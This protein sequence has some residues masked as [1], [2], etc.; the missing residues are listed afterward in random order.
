MLAKIT[1]TWRQALLIVQPATLL[2]WHRQRCRLFWKWK[3]RTCQPQPRSAAETS[4]LIRRM[5]TEN[6][7]WGAEH[8]RGELLKLGIEVAKRTIQQYTDRSDVSAAVRL[9][10]RRTE[11]T[12]CRSLWGDGVP[13]L[14]HERISEPS[15]YCVRS[16]SER[17]E[18]FKTS[19]ML[20]CV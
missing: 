3:S 15:T 9:L 14:V 8:I 11:I 18:K 7:L 13:D 5:C 1:R 19:L 17:L 12:A 16:T 2:R 4:A 6:P 20:T 10:H